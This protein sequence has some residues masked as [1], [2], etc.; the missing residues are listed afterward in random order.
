[1]VMKV[2]ASRGRGK[3]ERKN[4]QQHLWILMGL[5]ITQRGKAKESSEPNLQATKSNRAGPCILVLVAGHS[6]ETVQKI[7]GLQVLHGVYYVMITG[8]CQLTGA[9]LGAS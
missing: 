3:F 5:D 4:S 7:M 2:R 8:P 6:W 1:M 9:V